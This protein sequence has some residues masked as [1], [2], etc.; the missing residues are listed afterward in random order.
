MGKNMD[1]YTYYGYLWVIIWVYDKL[2]NI[3]YKP[4]NTGA[5]SRD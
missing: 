1:I 3:T 5:Y 4:G 2:R